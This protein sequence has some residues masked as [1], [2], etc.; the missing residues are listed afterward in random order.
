MG[1]GL[2]RDL[3]RIVGAVNVLDAPG[4]EWLTDASAARG[5]VGE[6]QA[7]ALP[8]DAREVADVLGWCC[9][10]GVPVVPRGG[11][12]GY[13]GGAVPAGGVV[14]ALERLRAVHELAP[15]S[16]RMCVGAGMTTADVR[17][18]ARE[19]GLLFA[20]DPGAAEQS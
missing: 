1:G 13:A 9:A 5:V 10:H 11:G 16:W 12:T 20:P 2:A 6:A 8:G 15:A 14:V 19:N 4:R 3:G 17:R 7:V 18:L